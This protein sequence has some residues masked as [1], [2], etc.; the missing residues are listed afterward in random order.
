MRTT[1]DIDAQI[2]RE[3]KRIQKKKGTVPGA[4][5]IQPVGASPEGGCGVRHAFSSRMDR[6][7]DGGPC[8][9]F[10]QGGGAPRIG[11]II[12]REVSDSQ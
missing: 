5:R 10:R 4:A 9:S 2:L 6:K 8:R 1:L 3:L 7:T 11:P 12:A